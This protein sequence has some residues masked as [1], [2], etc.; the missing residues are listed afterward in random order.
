MKKIDVMTLYHS[1]SPRPGDVIE[2]SNHLI[3]C[4][5]NISVELSDLRLQ[6][7][8]KPNKNYDQCTYGFN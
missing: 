2:H 8:K 3:F 4:N 5:F 7:P 6:V 1:K